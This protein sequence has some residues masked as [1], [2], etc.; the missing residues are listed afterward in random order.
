[1][2]YEKELLQEITKSLERLDV[3]V[4]SINMTLA[5]Q[6]IHL[7]EHIRRTALLEEEMKPVRDH[8]QRVNTLMLLLGGIL[9]LL[10]AVKTVVEIIKLF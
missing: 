10:G 4:D 3:S 5:K 6:E 8:V 1:M 7:A 2:D 9:A